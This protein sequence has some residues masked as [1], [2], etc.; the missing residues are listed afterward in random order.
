M[1]NKNN[2]IFKFILGVYAGY[3]ILYPAVHGKWNH[4]FDD[5]KILFGSKTEKSSKKSY[6]NEF[7]ELDSL[8]L[9]T[10][11]DYYGEKQGQVKFNMYIKVNRNSTQLNID[12][13]SA[14]QQRGYNSKSKNWDN[15][16]DF[17]EDEKNNRSNQLNPN[18]D[19]YYQSRGMDGRPNNW[20]NS[21]EDDSNSNYSQDELDN[22]AD[23]M[24]PNNDA[25]H[26]SR[27]N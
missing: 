14:W 6:R 8:T 24:N 7:Q 5:L 3:F 26:S 20:N 1:E 22:H 17:T 21:Y 19:K 18:N 16:Y 10:F 2:S 12:N 27:G 23:Q 15:D 11:K 9:E 13:D 4:R 25:Y